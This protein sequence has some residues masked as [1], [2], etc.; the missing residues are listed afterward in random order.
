MKKTP[1]TL[2]AAAAA[3]TLA[4]TGCSNAA[5]SGAEASGGAG[6]DSLPAGDEISTT[7]DAALTELLP[8]DIVEKGRID[9][10]VDIPF[11][12]MAMYDDSNRAIG[13]DP[14]SVASSARSSASTSR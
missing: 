7:T 5:T 10:A 9:I 11:P 1:L 8:D 3:L 13:F 14:S 2:L 4:I 12:P 6:G